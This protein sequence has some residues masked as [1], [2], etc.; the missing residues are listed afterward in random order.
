[1]RRATGDFA[2]SFINGALYPQPVGRLMPNPWGLFDAVGN[3]EEMTSDW[4]GE[5]PSGTHPNYAGPP[6]GEWRVAYG[7]SV[8]I[9]PGFFHTAPK[10]PGLGSSA[11]GFRVLREP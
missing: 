6:T 11:S 1:M 8:V 2:W 3:V 5:L 9:I 4:W 7:G 10:V